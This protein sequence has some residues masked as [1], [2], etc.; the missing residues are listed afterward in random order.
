[1][2]YWQHF[3]QSPIF[4]TMNVT[5]EMNDKKRIQKVK[6]NDFVIM[7][8]IIIEV[9]KKCNVMFFDSYHR[10]CI[11]FFTNHI[12]VSSFILPV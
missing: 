10:V 8:N 6:I 2:Q 4:S 12:N 9:D 5:N 7:G 3:Q 1:M 11:S